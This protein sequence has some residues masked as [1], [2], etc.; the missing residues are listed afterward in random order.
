M[1][2]LWIIWCSHGSNVNPGLSCIYSFMATEIAVKGSELD[3]DIPFRIIS[4]LISSEIYE[5][6]DRGGRYLS[7]SDIRAMLP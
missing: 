4:Y 5:K 3:M 6:Q 1:V 7:N 2:E